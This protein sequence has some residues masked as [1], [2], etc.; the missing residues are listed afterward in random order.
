[1]HSWVEPGAILRLGAARRLHPSLDASACPVA[2]AHLHLK[3]SAASL[4]W[5]GPTVVLPGDWRGQAADSAK[6]EE[7]TL[8]LAH[9]V[10]E[11]VVAAAESRHATLPCEG[12]KESGV[13]PRAPD[14]SIETQPRPKCTREARHVLPWPREHPSTYA[15][16]KE[17]A[18]AHYDAGIRILWQRNVD[19]G[20]LGARLGQGLA[21]KLIVAHH[22]TADRFI[23][24][25]CAIWA[26]VEDP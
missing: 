8:V 16:L 2:A 15:R 4:K 24:D 3:H 17:S 25:P 9:K 10:V 12:C 26:A 5:E 20:E 22:I 7:D 13:E 11:V 18:C 14:G 6:T 23:L 19:K 21:Q 1:M